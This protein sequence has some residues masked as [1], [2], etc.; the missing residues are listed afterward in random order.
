M[1]RT[2]LT[3]K[4]ETFCLRYFE[5]GNA[6]KAARL[7]GYRPRSASVIAAENLTKPLVVARLAELRKKAEDASVMSVLERKQRLSEIARAR[8]SDVVSAGPDGSWINIGL[9]GCQSAA[10]KSVKSRTE[11]GE[12]GAHPTVITDVELHDPIRAIAELNKLDGAYAPVKTEHSGSIDVH[13][14]VTIEV[15][16]MRLLKLVEA[17]KPVELPPD[18]GRAIL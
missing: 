14:T 1:G 7:A 18:A 17:P 8:L 5:L 9:D 16:R 13:E 10:L 6:T 2:G 11:Y 4:Q 15:L 12:N 3:Q